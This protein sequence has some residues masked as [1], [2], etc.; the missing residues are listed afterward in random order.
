MSTRVMLYDMYVKVINMSQ[1]M[2]TSMPINSFCVGCNQFKVITL[3]LPSS[4][5]SLP[6]IVLT[7]SMN[8]EL[9]WNSS[10][11]IGGI[12]TRTNLAPEIVLAPKSFTSMIVAK[13]TVVKFHDLEIF[14]YY[15]PPFLRNRHQP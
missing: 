6:N 8:W 13:H 11:S 2:D 5:L 15:S 4:G 9:F 10:Y 7:P 3:Y 14:L 12:L 1:Q